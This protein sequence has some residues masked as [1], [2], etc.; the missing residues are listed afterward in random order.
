MS[1]IM[2]QMTLNCPQN[3]K[4]NT[5]LKTHITS[6]TGIHQFVLFELVFDPGSPDFSHALCMTIFP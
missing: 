3:N 5:R 2:S 1:L 6:F 4:A